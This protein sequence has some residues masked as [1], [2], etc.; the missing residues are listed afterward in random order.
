M[1]TTRSRNWVF[2][3]NNYSEEELLA[4]RSL[5]TLNKDV[6]YICFGMEDGEACGTPHL[7]GYIELENIKS[8]RQLKK[9]IGLE[10][11]HFEERRGSQSQAIDYCKKD[12]LFEEYGEKRVDRTRVGNVKNKAGPFIEMIKEG[13]RLEEIACHPD[14]TAHMFRHVRD[15]SVMFEPPRDTNIPISVCWYWGP[16]G[17]GK[18]RRAWYEANKEEGG[19]YV[20]SSGGKWFDGYDGEENVIFDD[21]RS[22][23]FEF[24]FLLKLLDR[25][26]MRVECKGGSRQWK[27][28]KV[29]VTCPMKPDEMY[30]GVVA[31]DNAFNEANCEEKRD[32]IAQLLRRVHVVQHMPMTPFGGWVEPVEELPEPIKRP[33][34]EEEEE[35]ET[36]AIPLMNPELELPPKAVFSPTQDWCTQM[37]EQPKP[38]EEES[39][40]GSPMDWD[41]PLYDIDWFRDSGW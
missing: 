19:V 25:Y 24:S 39:L 29:W 11:A 31:R 5:T 40:F 26:P 35:T 33:E 7:Q 23:W 32:Q 2:T 34:P 21:L 41:D 20:K 30:Q 8:L 1:T 9:L 28:L 12:G 18:T 4:V 14:M 3:L 38:W 17:T 6:K 27:A 22:S 36:E 15:L 13:V 16:T 37:L 10:R